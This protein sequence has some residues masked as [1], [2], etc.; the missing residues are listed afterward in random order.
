MTNTNVFRNNYEHP[1][2]ILTPKKLLKARLKVRNEIRLTTSTTTEHVSSQIKTFDF[3]LL[4]R[5]NAF[6]ICHLLPVSMYRMCVTNRGEED[7]K[8]LCLREK[9]IAEITDNE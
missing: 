9:N 6:Y 4:S 3:G 8:K 7:E 1:L 2:S 5:K